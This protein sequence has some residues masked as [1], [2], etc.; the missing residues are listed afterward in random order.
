MA[1][2]ELLAGAVYGS[3]RII[4]ITYNGVSHATVVEYEQRGK[5]Y[6]VLEAEFRRIVSYNEFEDAE[7]TEG[8]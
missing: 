6:Y 1:K 3:V 4:T 5:R 2:P 8:E 7:T